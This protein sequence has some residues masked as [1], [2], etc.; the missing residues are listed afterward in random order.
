VPPHVSIEPEFH[1]NDGWKDIANPIVSHHR[2]WPN[3]SLPP[4][5]PKNPNIR[6]SPVHSPIQSSH[7]RKRIKTDFLHV[8][9]KG[10]VVSS[11]SSPSNDSSKLVPSCMHLKDDFSHV[12]S[13]I[14]PQGLN[15]PK[16]SS[17][18][19]KGDN[20]DRRKIT[21]QSGKYGF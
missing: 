1:E 5:P 17:G 14:N 20:N 4:P 7:A 15:Q 16:N 19:S 13:E 3:L 9:E 2:G 21:S 8:Q 10:K 6:I 12:I 18:N 11:P